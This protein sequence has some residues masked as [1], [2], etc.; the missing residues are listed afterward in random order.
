MVLVLAAI[1]GLGGCLVA[2]NA[3][4]RFRAMAS[5]S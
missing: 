1:S 2:P 4:T 5:D 3:T